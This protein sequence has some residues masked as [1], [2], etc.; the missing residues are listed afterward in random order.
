MSGEV[1]QTSDSKLNRKAL[2]QSFLARHPRLR[3]DD[4]SSSSENDGESARPSKTTRKS[5][6]SKT[7]PAK[8]KPAAVA[9]TRV[10]KTPPAKMRTS[11]AVQ[12]P[13][14]TAE[15]EV[16]PTMQTVQDQRDKEDV[17]GDSPTIVVKRVEKGR[18]SGNGETK[19]SKTATTTGQASA[20]AS[21]APSATRSSSNTTEKH[22]NTRHYELEM[23]KA[24]YPVDLS[25]EPDFFEA[26]KEY[27][28]IFLLL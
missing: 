9:P 14:E 16:V 12:K 3:A 4:D 11:T 28:V 21:T 10:S 18:K 25:E 17:G 13:K 7:P 8:M 20:N 1:S 27:L 6:L 19:R 23:F 22:F 26:S 15:M 5:R 2:I 24:L